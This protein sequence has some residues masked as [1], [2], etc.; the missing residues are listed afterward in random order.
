MSYR[1]S[2]GCSLRVVQISDD[3]SDII[4]RWQSKRLKTQLPS[5]AEL[6]ALVDQPLL[7]DEKI[8]LGYD[9][10][11]SLINTTTPAARC[12]RVQVGALFRSEDGLGYSALDKI[13]F[14]VSEPPPLSGTEASFHSF[15]DSNVRSILELL[16]P[17]GRSIRDSSQHTATGLLRPDYGFLLRNLC[18]FRGEEKPPDSNEDPKEELSTKLA[19]AYDPAPYVLG[20]LM[21]TMSSI[22]F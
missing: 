11:L 6:K 8:P 3:V 12:S 5:I 22:N 2:I 10:F 16:I 1:V 20:Q 13:F 9:R 7:D 19:W 14:I 18:T 4:G 21:S 17:V 15:W